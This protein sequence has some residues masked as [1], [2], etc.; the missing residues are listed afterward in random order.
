[1]DID[2]YKFTMGQL[3][4]HRYL[5]V[6]VKYSLKVRTAGT[7]MARRIK[8]DDLR[9][10]LDHAMTLGFNNS[11]LHYLRGTNEYS[12]RMFKEDYLEFLRKFKLPS[13]RLEW[14]DEEFNL[15]FPGI[16][17]SK[18]YWETIALT[19]INELYFRGIMD[20]LSIFERDV[21]YA[22]GKI[23]LAEKIKL[24]KEN[25]TVT[26]SDFGTRRRFSKE[27][28]DY[29]VR[30]LAE[31]LPR[32]QF[33]G[34]SN[35]ALANKY[36]L[37]PI[38]TSAHELFMIMAGMMAESDEGIRASV[39]KVL[40]DWWDEYGWG[41]SIALPDTFGTD[42]FLPIFGGDRAHFWK[43][44]RQDSGDPYEYGDKKIIPFYEGAG[45]DPRG[46]IIVFSDGL[47]IEEM[48]KIQ[49]HFA[50]R[51]KTTFG[52]GTNLTNNL[53]FPAVSMVVKPVEACGRG[54]VKLSDNIAKAIG[55]PEDIERYKKI[56]G[57]N[58]D[59]NKAC[60]Y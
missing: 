28:H 19:V 46:K 56:F 49:R 8:E 20:S 44:T 17:A 59:F 45:V 23:K 37:M 60:V 35:V 25:P 51:I 34:T 32:S 5:D 26:F 58:A 33:I 10:E 4:F 57:Y 31:E 47:N 50:G 41:L 7:V 55:R 9:K 12:E 40:D 24:L 30:V 11:E 21:I 29:I 16:W 39:S 14:G 13:Y 22:T 42:S 2:F 53:G 15:E 52:W 3:V 43:G 54:L 36:G 1:M 6:P 18:I 27:W 38:G 48:I